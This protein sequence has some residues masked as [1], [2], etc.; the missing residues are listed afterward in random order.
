MSIFKWKEKQ[1]FGANKENVGIHECDKLDT[2]R[3]KW[4]Y[5]IHFIRRGKENFDYQ[6]E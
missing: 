4:I 1:K 6:N 2:E 5:I 3:N